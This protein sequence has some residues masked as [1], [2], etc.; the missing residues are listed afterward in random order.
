[1][2]SGRAVRFFSCLWMC[3]VSVMVGCRRDTDSTYVEREDIAKLPAEY[4][5]QIRAV[6]KR[7]F[8]TATAPRFQVPNFDALDE[9]EEGAELELINEIEPV[10]LRQGQA[11]FNRR[12]SGC[13]GVTGDGAGPAAPHL[14]PKPRDYRRGIFKFGSVT[15]GS[16]PVR[17]DL[18]RFIRH[19]ARGT[20]MPAFRWLPDDE[21][22]AIVSY[23][24]MLSCRG[25]FEFNLIREANDL[26]IEPED[27]EEGEE[28]ELIEEEVIPE[29][30]DE[31]VEAWHTAA[32]YVVQ[33]VTQMPH[34]TPES[35]EAGRQAF[36]GRECWKCHGRDG[37]GQTTWLN[38]EFLAAL[39]KLPEAER[40]QLN[41]DDWGEIAPAADLSAGML[42][43]GRR[44][45]DVYRRIYAGINGTPMPAFSVAFAEEP[46][47]IWNLVHF[48]LNV[49]ETG[50][51]PAQESGDAAAGP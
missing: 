40:E 22:Q 28:Q 29:F 27:L 13:H 51:F 41:H 44:P 4:Q 23:V 20:S 42:H 5:A 12:C 9:D 19:G 49:V 7:Y 36:M 18:V 48:V 3:L 15:R 2:Q 8:G 50:R 25:E 34:V 46:D 6:L 38:K 17:Q 47:T 32:E 33:P 26:Y 45:I 1:M 37:R 31:I 43:G 24:I 16:K 10:V 14:T 35:I 30:L 39:E 11:A 21:M